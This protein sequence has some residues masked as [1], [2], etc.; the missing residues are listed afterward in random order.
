[1]QTG[2]KRRIKKIIRIYSLDFIS[3]F[4]EFTGFIL[5]KS[6][7]DRPGNAAFDSQNGSFLQSL[8]ENR[9]KWVFVS[10]FYGIHHGHV[11]NRQFEFTAVRFLAVCILVQKLMLVSHCQIHIVWR[12]MDGMDLG[13]VLLIMI[14][15]SSFILY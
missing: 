11:E 1:M 14:I 8:F 3:I 5:C 10:S 7:N 9:L 6:D 12:G 2:T 13:Y 4:P 15:T